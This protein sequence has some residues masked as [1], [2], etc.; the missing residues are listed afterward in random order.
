[1]LGFGTAAVLRSNAA[2]LN[3][4]IQLFSVHEN[5][6]VYLLFGINQPNNKLITISI[7]AYKRLSLTR[8]FVCGKN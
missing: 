5:H 2:A 3:V 6:L 8:L 4:S 1:M 7:A